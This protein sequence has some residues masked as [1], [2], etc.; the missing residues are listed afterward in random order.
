MRAQNIIFLPFAI[1]PSC[2]TDI[3]RSMVAA[4]T[5]DDFLS[6]GKMMQVHSSTFPAYFSN[7]KNFVDS[8]PP[9]F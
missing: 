5:H 2:Q 8:V 3:S 6:G 7:A 4:F 9:G 1:H